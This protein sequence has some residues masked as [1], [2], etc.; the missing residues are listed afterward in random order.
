MNAA[1]KTTLAAVVVVALI[2]SSVGV[3]YSWFS[4]S[5]EYTVE[6]GTATFD[7]GYSLY[8]DDSLV[9]DNS[10]DLM[11]GATNN[12]VLSMT[13]NND[14]PVAFEASFTVP[15][16]IAYS[17]S[18]HAGSG[19]GELRPN[20]DGSY[21]FDEELTLAHRNGYRTESIN[22]LT[23]DFANSGASTLVGTNSTFTTIISGTTYYVVKTSYSAT[24]SDIILPHSTMNIPIIV[25]TTRTVGNVTYTYTEGSTLDPI[26]SAESMQINSTGSVAETSL[27]SMGDTYSGLFD[28]SQLNGRTSLV[29]S[30]AEDRFRI[31]MDWQSLSTPELERISVIVTI[32][33]DSISISVTGMDSSNGTVQLEGR[34]NYSIS[35]AGGGVTSVISGENSISCTVTEN[36]DVTTVTFSDKSSSTSHTI[37]LAGGA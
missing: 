29:F 2:L 26:I 6:I 12:L 21:T 31:T 20:G 13:N 16:Y 4:A 37:G 28:L 15:R 9:T 24:Y 23:V 17:T 14:V 5:Q 11:N 3:T 36:G 1:M 32:I 25:N 35:I 18:D 22:A 27:M 8:S 7:V 10:V 34:V 19:E 33:S 30:D